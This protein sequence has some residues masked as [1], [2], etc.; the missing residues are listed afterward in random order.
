[1]YKSFHLLDDSTPLRL[2]EVAAL[3]NAQKP[4]QTVEENEETKEYVPNKRTR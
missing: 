1:M 3:S 4:T 2:G